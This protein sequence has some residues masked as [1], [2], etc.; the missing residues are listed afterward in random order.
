MHAAADYTEQL[1]AL[2]P[3]GHAWPRSN[4]SWLG[5]LLA[6]LAEEFA[7]VDGRA[8]NLLDEADPFTTLELLPDWERLA[9]LPDP[10]RPI[11]ESVRERRIAVAR[12]VA[13]L[14][15]QTPAFLV[16]LAAS[17]GYEVDIVEFDVFAI[18]SH[19]GDELADD[20]WRHAFLVEAFSTA[21]AQWF[22]IGSYAGERL[23]TWGSSNLE[24][25]VQ[26]AKPAHS[27]ALFAYDLQPEAI[28]WFDFT[29]N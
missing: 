22:T 20:D 23:R 16:E 14:G 11:A 9:G 7:R 21:E 12:K 19:I 29:V 15:G 18:G 26:R 6:G 17:A 2:L 27:I 13:G 5:R 8:F 25:L 28:L 1:Q 3:Q 4:D 24:C 10:C